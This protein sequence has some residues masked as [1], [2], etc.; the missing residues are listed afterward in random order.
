VI[1]NLFVTKIPD[2]PDLVTERYMNVKELLNGKD[3]DDMKCPKCGKE[4]KNP[5]KEWDLTPKVH[6]KLYSCCGKKIRE[7]MSK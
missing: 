1:D 7:Y 5:V 3:L 2:L 6:V 4:L